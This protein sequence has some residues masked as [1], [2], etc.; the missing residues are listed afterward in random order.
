MLRQVQHHT[1]TRAE[2]GDTLIEV[3]LAIT[4]FSM[5]IVAAIAMMNQGTATSQRALEITLVRQSI[6]AQADTLRYLQA[7]YVQ[8]YPI[9][10]T[11]TTPS[12]AREFYEITQQSVAQASAFG[13][14]PCASP[15]TGSFTLNTRTAELDTRRTL[16]GNPATFAQQQYTGTTLTASHGLWVEAVR[17]APSGSGGYIDFH[18]RGCW[19]TAGSRQPMNLGTIVRLYEPR[20]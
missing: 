8:S 13:T 9:D 2:A 14:V 12:P 3:I 1:R 17:S 19:A 15:P 7:A 10:T 16:F 18:I 20:G 4:I 6:D 5:I 11:D